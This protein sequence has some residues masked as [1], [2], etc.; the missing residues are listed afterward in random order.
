LCKHKRQI[1]FSFAR[2]HAY[3]AR[4]R[5][6]LVTRIHPQHLRL[7]AHALIRAAA[8]TH[9]KEGGKIGA[10]GLPALLFVV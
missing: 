1:V 2:N 6:I 10:T 3:R 5:T 8:H 7:A 4:R 9:E